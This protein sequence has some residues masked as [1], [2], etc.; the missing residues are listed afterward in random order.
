MPPVKYGMNKAV[1]YPDTLKTVRISPTG[2]TNNRL[3]NKNLQ[4]SEDT[5]RHVRRII[6]RSFFSLG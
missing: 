5:W 4:V 6:S 3:V 2:K 1:K